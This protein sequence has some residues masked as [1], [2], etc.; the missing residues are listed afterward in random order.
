VVGSTPRS[1]SS[2]K[3]AVA[4]GMCVGTAL[5]AAAC[6]GGSATVAPSV[7]VYA[8]TFAATASLSELRTGPT[9][10]LLAD[11]QVLMA[12]GSTGSASLAT[13]ELFDA[14][15]GTFGATGSMASPR[16]A[17]SATLLRDGRVLFIGGWSGS[18][19]LASAEIYDPPSARF[20]VTGSMSGPRDSSTATRLT[21]GRVL[22]VGGYSGTSASSVLGSA[23]TFDPA[24]GTFSSTGPMTVPRAGHS[25]T[26]LADGR[27]LIAGGETT[28]SKIVASA[29]IY[30]P[31][32]GAFSPVASPMTTPRSN[33][34]ATL[35]ADGRVLI[36]GG[37]SRSNIGGALASAE[38][39]D[40]ASAKF[41]STGSMSVARSDDTSTMLA[42]GR[43]LMVG[44]D[45]GSMDAI[46][47][48]EIYDPK[49]GA[50]TTTGSMANPRCAHAATA[51]SD[52]RVLVVGGWAGKIAL[53][54]AEIYS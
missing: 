36:A 26:L 27:V 43:V 2:R 9:A 39:Y 53:A 46:G 49:A 17:A 29:E 35:L 34:S 20:N 11:G 32:S 13:A 28:G 14:T 47:S 42:D 40:P 5:M 25:A 12:G 10:T 6:S 52:G 18:T 44:G 23:E 3:H 24:S 31:N 22:V 50:F 19:T 21:D 1:L 38:I 8:G 41:T 54:S 37:S 48:A 33:Q 15:T 4:L 45:N 16:T 30:D 51:L 7:R